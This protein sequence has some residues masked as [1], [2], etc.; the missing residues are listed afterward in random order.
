MTLSYLTL[1][2]FDNGDIMRLLDLFMNIW[3]A[4]LTL[5]L[6]NPAFK[7]AVDLLLPF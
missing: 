5:Y 6:L 7:A 3:L 4:C 2:S 1:T